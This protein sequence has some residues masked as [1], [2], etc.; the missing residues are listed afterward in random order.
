MNESNIDELI[1]S[2]CRVGDMTECIAR[3]FFGFRDFMI[4]VKETLETDIQKIVYENNR[5]TKSN[6]WLKQHGYPM[7]RRW[8]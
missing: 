6:N 5:K 3:A 8:K 1:E 2:F 7:R 4:H